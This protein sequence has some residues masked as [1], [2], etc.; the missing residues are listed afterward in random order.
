MSN[1]MG[2]QSVKWAFELKLPPTATPAMK[3]VLVAVAHTKNEKT[4]QCFPGQVLLADMT[5]QSR[6]TVGRSL[7]ALESLG[8][9]TRARR[10]K[11]GQYRTS[12][13]FVL[14]TS[15]AA[16]SNVAE[17]HVAESHVAEGAMSRSNASILMPHSDGVIE[18]IE[19]IGKKEREVHTAMVLFAAPTV[20]DFCAL[21]PRKKDKPAATRAWAN[22]VKKLPP[23]QI[24]AAAAAYA[25]NPHMPAK[26][27]VPYPATWLN[28]EGWNDDLEGPHEAQRTTG[29]PTPT[30]RV[31]AILALVP[32]HGQ[33]A[34]NS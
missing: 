18:E 28:A 6:A 11:T 9:I 16:E 34:I 4:G 26:Q 29:K 5:S 24:L 15:Y 2:H 14:N 10:K 12:D 20:D 21:W 1:R 27:Y 8:V 25:A 19:E 31:A 30:D 22:A 32:D 33:K 3:S 17:S 13:D 23:E 7:A